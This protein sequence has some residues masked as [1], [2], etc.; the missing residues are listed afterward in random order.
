MV[1]LFRFLFA[2][3]TSRFRRPLG[4]LDDCVIAMRVWPNDL[5]LN[6]HMNSGRYLS[7]MDIGRVEILARTRLLRPVLRRGWRPMV[8]ATFIRYRR[9]LL[10]FERFTVRSHIVCW[11][12]KWLYFEHILERRGEVAAHAYVR[13]LLRGREG[14]VRPK[15]LLELAGTPELASPAMPAEIEAWRRIIDPQMTQMEGR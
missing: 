10:P 4:V 13:G 1:V 8:G 9:S 5:D 14:N 7:M 11:D 2:I 15:E 6:M 3:F 12:E